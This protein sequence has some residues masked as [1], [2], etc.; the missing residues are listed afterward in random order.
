RS[1]WPQLQPR[2]QEAVQVAER[3]LEGQASQGALQAAW[4]DVRNLLEELRWH[5]NAY[6]SRCAGLGEGACFPETTEGQNS[7]L[8]AWGRYPRYKAVGLEAI[9]G[10]AVHT[11]VIGGKAE[12]LA[13][14]RLVRD[15]LGNPFR[16]VTLD[17]GW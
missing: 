1:V 3:Y 14:Y 8:D 17:A 16:P 9:A 11:R 5:Q 4:E 15:I 12:R 10:V 13:P 2:I 6:P 7:V